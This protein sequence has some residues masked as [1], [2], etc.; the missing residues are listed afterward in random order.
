MQLLGVEQGAPT[1]S[2][3][4]TNGQT[5]ETVGE[6]LPELDTVASLTLIIEAID[7]G[8]GRQPTSDVCFILKCRD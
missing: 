4:H 2:V 3:L 8:G 7:P 6:G 5:V 1:W